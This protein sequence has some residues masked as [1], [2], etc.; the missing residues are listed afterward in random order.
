L[1]HAE[2]GLGDTIQFARYAPLLAHAG[3]KVVLEAPAALTSLLA[4]IDGVAAVVARGEPLPEFDVQCPLGSLPLALKT[5][6]ATVPADIPY[7]KISNERLAK[8]RP[9]IERLRAPRIAVAWSGSAGHVNDRNRSIGVDRLIPLLADERL[10][11]LSIQRDLRDGD[12]E[13]LARHPRL[14]HVGA[15][16]DDFD[17]TAA[18]VALADVII[19][20]DTSAVHLSGALGRP[21]WVLLPF[22]PDWRWGLNAETSPWYPTIRLFRQPSRG[23]WDSVLARIA[24]ALARL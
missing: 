5:E 21:T 3:A 12:V 11:F 18:V 24:E 16:L 4:R 6:P 14:E 17:D 19:S 7:L 23:D 20:V 1:L 22:C 10:S 15:D 13:A 8:W 9:R 2:Q